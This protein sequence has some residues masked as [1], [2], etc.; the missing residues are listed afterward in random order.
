[1]AGRPYEVDNRLL[2]E[3]ALVERHKLLAGFGDLRLQDS[4]KIVLWQRWLLAGKQSQAWQ[5]I[6]PLSA[7]TECRLEIHVRYIQQ[8]LCTCS[9][10]GH[11][12]VWK[13][14]AAVCPSCIVFARV[15]VPPA[16][17]E[18]AIQEHQCHLKRDGK[19]VTWQTFQHSNSTRCFRSSSMS[20][21]PLPSPCSLYST[22]R[23]QVC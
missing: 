20:A 17:L 23:T 16:V 19:L 4:V 21:H 5:S 2:N 14:F 3:H 10:Q 9:I 13:V 8:L 1:M 18:V 6:V 11:T 22:A 12:A 15:V 7:A